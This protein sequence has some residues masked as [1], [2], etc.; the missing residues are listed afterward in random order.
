M[1]KLLLLLTLTGITLRSLPQA[2]DEYAADLSQGAAAF[3]ALGSWR[4]V[5]HLRPGLDVPINFEIKAGRTNTPELFFRNAAEF[6]EGGA[7]RQ[8]ADSLFIPLNQFDNELAFQIKG[9][10]LT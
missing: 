1:R 7:I 9:D 4:G 8:T 2:A 5:F 6:F 10:S 3:N